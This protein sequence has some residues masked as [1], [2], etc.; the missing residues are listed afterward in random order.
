VEDPIRR[1]VGLEI[2]VEAPAVSIW[3]WSTPVASRQL[4]TANR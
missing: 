1:T 3:L 4:E 2:T